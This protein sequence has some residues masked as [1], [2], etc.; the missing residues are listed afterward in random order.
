M[1]ESINVFVK[2]INE[3]ATFLYEIGDDLLSFL[4]NLA[5]IILFTSISIFAFSKLNLS[6][7]DLSNWAVTVIAFLLLII[8][9]TAMLI[10]LFKFSENSIRSLNQLKKLEN[11]RNRQGRK[12]KFCEAFY[13]LWKKGA[14]KQIV[15]F[16]SVMLASVVVVLV[17]AVFASYNFYKITHGH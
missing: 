17:A 14:A 7:V 2:I 8:A 12:V 5:P 16:Y 1:K 15:I 10:N 4:R 11:Y 13:Y 9:F 3:F 6:K